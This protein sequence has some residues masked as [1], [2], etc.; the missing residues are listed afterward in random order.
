M[1]ILK[2]TA[3]SA[4]LVVALSGMTVPAA[5]AFAPINSI[6]WFCDIFPFACDP[7]PR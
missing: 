3:A 6:E 4:A 2:M 7:R 5:D 1:K